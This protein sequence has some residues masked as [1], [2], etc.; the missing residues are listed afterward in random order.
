MV[1]DKEYPEAMGKTKKEA[2]EEAAELVYH[3]ICGSQTA[4]VRLFLLASVKAYKIICFFLSGI[5]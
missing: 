3:E 4:N 1:G 2:K 5:L